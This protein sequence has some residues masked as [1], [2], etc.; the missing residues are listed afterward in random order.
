VRS[1]PGEART[2]ILF[3]QEQLK[4]III[5]LGGESHLDVA[6]SLNNMDNIYMRPGKYEEALE[7]HRKSLE[8]RTRIYGGDSHPL[9]ADSWNHIGE[10]LR[11]TG[12]YEETLEMHA[13]SLETQVPHLWWRQPP[14]CS[15]SRATRYGGHVPKSCCTVPESGKPSTGKQNG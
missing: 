1:G 13:K 11:H 15:R 12:R 2:T 6:A 8:I 5:I 4:D 9:V 14:R 3:L 10:V 7:V